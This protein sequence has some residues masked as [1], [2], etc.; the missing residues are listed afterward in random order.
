MRHKAIFQFPSFVYSFPFVNCYPEKFEYAAK[1]QE[2]NT[3][4]DTIRRMRE[5]RSDKHLLKML[6]WWFLFVGSRESAQKLRSFYQKNPD[7]KNW[8]GHFIQPM[9]LSHTKSTRFRGKPRLDFFKFCSE[10]SKNCFG[11][12]VKIRSSNNYIFY[13]Y[14]DDILSITTI[15]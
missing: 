5:R 6:S 3:F 11:A 7:R 14:S 12:K 8:K 9:V 1:K 10:N 13:T 4:M 15:F 2:R